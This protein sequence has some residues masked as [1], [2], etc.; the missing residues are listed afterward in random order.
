MK[1]KHIK[2]HC[3]E[4]LCYRV[5]YS[6]EIALIWF[7]RL[8]LTAVFPYK[9]V[10]RLVGVGNLGCRWLLSIEVSYNCHVSTIC[11]PCDIKLWESWVS[12][13]ALLEAWNVMLV[14]FAFTFLAEC[15][16]VFR[17]TRINS[18]TTAYFQSHLSLKKY[19]FVTFPD[20]TTYKK[21]RT[22]NKCEYT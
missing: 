22:L 4:L 21:F 14:M 19:H 9:M 5:N 12:A 16:H 7:D 18:R 20:K 1:K 15:T 6:L 11:F 8:L 2:R 17:L 13:V 10:S 3:V